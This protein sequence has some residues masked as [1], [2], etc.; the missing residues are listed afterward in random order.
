MMRPSWKNVRVV[1]RRDFLATVRR[2]AYIFTAIG[3]PAYFALVTYLT[4]AP[5]VSEQMRSL[6]SLNAVGVVDSSGLFSGADRTIHTEIGENPFDR[7]S[8]PHQLT[9]E[10]SF[11]PSQ[12]EALT[13]LREKKIAQVLVIPPD[14]LESGHIARYARSSSL[15]SNAD[16]GP[17]RT[18]LSRS[19]IS[20]YAPGDR[21]ERAVRPTQ[22]LD[23]Y[24]L[25]PKTEQ[26]ELK[27][28][29]REMA[30]F[31]VPFGL[32]MLLSI[33]ITIGGQYLLQG[34]AEERESRILESL[35]CAL[36]PDELLWGKLLGL[37]AAGMLLI[38]F[39]TT[40]GI[41]LAGPALALIHPT[42]MLGVTALV[43]FLLG[44][45]FYSSI[46][47]GVGSV[48]TSLREAIQISTMFTFLNFVPFILLTVIL[49][50]PNGTTA[51][52]L[53]MVPFTAATTMMLR[54]VSPTNAVPPWQLGLSLAIMVVSAWL[55]LNASARVFRTGL[56]L[57]GKR[58]TLPEILRWIRS[59]A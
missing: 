41:G 31:L 54:L 7:K 45:L 9:T 37:G 58:P 34:L 46:L 8:T 10:V 36:S 29:A 39:W 23:D 19:L 24:T 26:F 4:A 32:A 16:R 22:H 27:N 55:V 18:W 38:V 44:Y 49:S 33:G 52:I 43:Y 14:Y 25:N 17:V 11:Y 40:L 42:P 21:V 1:A 47:T 56:L 35:L 12:A 6:K 59:P 53:S 57:Y 51:V 30:D 5:Q 13:A 3:M 15:F 48:A 50:Q 2:K 28:D 20:A